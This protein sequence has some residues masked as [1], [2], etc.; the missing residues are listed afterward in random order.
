MLVIDEIWAST[1]FRC[2]C[3][4]L[5][6]ISLIFFIVLL[7]SHYFL[8]FPKWTCTFCVFYNCPVEVTS[9]YNTVVQ[10]NTVSFLRT[11]HAHLHDFVC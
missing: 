3:L 2:I 7:R 8:Y 6:L 10:L 11:I 1:N 5:L 4:K 9:P